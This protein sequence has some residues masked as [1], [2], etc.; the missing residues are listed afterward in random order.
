M[1]HWVQQIFRFAF[2]IVSLQVLSF[3]RFLVASL[4]RFL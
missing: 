2:E 4:L 1:E 3:I